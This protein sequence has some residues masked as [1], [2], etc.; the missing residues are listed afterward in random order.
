[1]KTGSGTLKGN[2]TNASIA[3]R[4][5]IITGF[6][7]LA[8]LAASCRS[9]RTVTSSE[10]QRS[11]SLT[12]DSTSVRET[13]DIDTLKVKEDTVEITI[14]QSW[15]SAAHDSSAPYWSSSV[16]KRSGRATLKVTRTP[17]GLTVEGK[18]DSLE[19][20]CF[21]RTMEVFR[22]KSSIDSLSRSREVTDTTTKVIF[23]IPIWAIIALVTSMAINALFIYLKIRPRTL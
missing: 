21:N 19:A 7:L 9:T 23:R 16:T 18:C 17:Q 10:V 5:V 13:I 1:M 2:R 22:L 20:L 8:L 11:S 14:P 12:S 15:L 6:L 4:S 3:M